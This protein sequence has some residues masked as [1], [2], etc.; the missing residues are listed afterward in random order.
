MYPLTITIQNEEE[1]LAVVKALSG[2]AKQGPQY[3]EMLTGPRI[4]MTPAGR[5]TVNAN[6]LSDAQRKKSKPS[7]H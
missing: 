2:L 5:V 7:T 4:V 3:L 6:E 1:Y